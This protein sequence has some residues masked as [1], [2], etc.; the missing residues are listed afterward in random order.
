MD[1]EKLRRGLLEVRIHYRNLT[2]FVGVGAGE[3]QVPQIL[4][5]ALRTRMLAHST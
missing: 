5:R 2:G 4:I 3:R 1:G